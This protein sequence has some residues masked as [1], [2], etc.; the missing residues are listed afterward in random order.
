MQYSYVDIITMLMTVD[1]FELLRAVDGSILMARRRVGSKRSR[2]RMGQYKDV[3]HSTFYIFYV[4]TTTAV[5]LPIPH[6]FQ[7]SPLCTLI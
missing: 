3:R 5:F 2:P 4:G 1:T 7:T 6:I